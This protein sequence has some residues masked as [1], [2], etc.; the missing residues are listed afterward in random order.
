MYIFLY[1]SYRNY[2]NCYFSSS[3]SSFF[4]SAIQATG[5]IERLRKKADGDKH[6][7]RKTTSFAVEED[8]KNLKYVQYSVALSFILQHLLVRFFF[9]LTFSFLFSFSTPKQRLEI[10]FPI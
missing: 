5:E 3:S 8:D 7:V 9:S 1:F 6:H 2:F 10:S 4:S